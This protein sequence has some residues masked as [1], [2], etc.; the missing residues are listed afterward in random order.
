MVANL[1]I[2]L[3]IGITFWAATWIWPRVIRRVHKR[4]NN[5]MNLYSKYAPHHDLILRLYLIIGILAIVGVFQLSQ[6][7]FRQLL[8]GL[9]S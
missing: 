6:M 2:W 9:T 1:S 4:A 8:T 3:S 7:A 5:F